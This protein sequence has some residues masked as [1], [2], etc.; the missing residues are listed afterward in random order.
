MI[1]RVGANLHLYGEITWHSKQ[2]ENETRMAQRHL[3]A[4]GIGE[5][6]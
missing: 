2:N 1:A 6:I 4:S 5:A 3:P